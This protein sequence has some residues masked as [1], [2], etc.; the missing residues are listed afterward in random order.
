MT[1]RVL[2]LLLIIQLSCRGKDA[3]EVEVTPVKRGTFMEE[4]TDQVIFRQ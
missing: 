2:F 4:L 3:T 1:K